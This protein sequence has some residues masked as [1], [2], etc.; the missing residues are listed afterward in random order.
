MNEL[1]AIVSGRVQMV[2]YRDFVVRNARTFELDGEVKNLPDGTVKV[3]AQGER[4]ELEMLLQSL[5]EGPVLAHV[6]TVVVKWVKP[7]VGYNGFHIVYE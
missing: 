6:D 5:R 1:Q 4:P 7:S 2:M 3:I